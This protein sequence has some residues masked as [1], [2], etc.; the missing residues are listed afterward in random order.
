MHSFSK[1]LQELSVA[2]LGL[3]LSISIS[4]VGDGGLKEGSALHPF[5]LFFAGSSGCWCQASLFP[6]RLQTQKDKKS[7]ILCVLS[8]VDRVPTAGTHSSEM[9]QGLLLPAPP[10]QGPCHPR[11]PASV[12]NCCLVS[13]PTPIIVPLGEDQCCPPAEGHN[14]V[15]R[16]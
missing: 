11:V 2:C 1:Y 9:S 7:L 3:V 10:H 13:A 12:A 5:L 4:Q 8:T 6:R 15:R 14:E 16:R